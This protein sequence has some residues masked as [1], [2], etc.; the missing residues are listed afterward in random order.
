MAGICIY[1]EVVSDK[2]NESFAEL[3]TAA[4]EIRKVSDE[5]IIVLLVTDN[6]EDY[7]EDVSLEGVDEIHI[8][9]TKGISAYATDVLSSVMCQLIQ[10]AEPSCILIPASSIACSVFARTAV[11]LEIGMTSDCTNL[12]A[13]ME[14]GNL[15]IRQNKPS[16]GAQV[17]VSCIENSTP[18]L[19]SIVSGAYLPAKRGGMPSIVK[20]NDIAIGKSAISL[21]EEKLKSESTGIADA[22]IVVCVGRGAMAE[23]NLE[24]AKEFADKIGAHLGGTR[25]LADNGYLSFEDQIGQTGCVIRPKVCIA[26]GISGAIQF[27]EGIKGNPLFIGVNNDSNAAIFNIADYA[28]VADMQDILREL[29]CSSEE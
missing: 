22:E 27:T 14:Q 16:F 6:P 25:P 28:V 15:C 10:K 11:L 1:A 21:R 26:F 23:N 5:N 17:I 3:V 7:I 12:E 9:E 20:V 8:L 24:L 19:I 29:L 4:K 18:Q 13:V 2:V